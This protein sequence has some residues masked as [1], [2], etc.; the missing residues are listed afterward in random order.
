[1]CEKIHVNLQNRAANELHLI[2]LREAN[3][4]ASII[5]GECQAIGYYCEAI[6]VPAAGIGPATNVL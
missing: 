4:I 2:D 1:M 3:T 5:E 6:L